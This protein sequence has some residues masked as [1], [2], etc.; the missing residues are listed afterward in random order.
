M[1]KPGSIRML[2]HPM[3]NRWRLIGIGL[4]LLAGSG[5]IWLAHS[6]VVS[7]GVNRIALETGFES[8]PLQPDAPAAEAALS[9]AAQA[10]G[11]EMQLRCLHSPIWPQQ[12]GETISF[13]VDLVN[14]SPLSTNDRIR[15]YIKQNTGQLIE[16]CDEGELSCTGSASFAVSSIA[17]QCQAIITGGGQRVDISSGVRSIQLG[18]YTQAR[19]VPV[20][21]TGNEQN[22]AIDVVFIPDRVSYSGAADPGFLD[23]V[24]TVISGTYY[25]Q[26]IYLEHQ[27]RLNF[28]IAQDTGLAQSFDPTGCDGRP[29]LHQL[30]ANWSSANGYAFADVGIILHDKSP[31]EN[32]GHPGTRVF[33]ANAATSQGTVRY[34]TG[35]VPFGLADEYTPDGGYFQVA[36]FPNVYLVQSDCDRDPLLNVPCQPL[37][38]TTSSFTW[39][40][41]DA[42]NVDQ[43]MMGRGEEAQAADNRRIDW[44][45]GE[46]E[47]GNCDR[48]AIPPELPPV[49]P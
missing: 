36:P 31:F 15:L 11:A 6:A 21:Y 16:R 49:V 42:V 37:P 30:P 29:C 44:L 39:Y 40:R 35:H 26:T 18:P 45:F 5:G 17:Y 25:G 9:P 23:A 3:L 10:T 33:S 19:A 38:N 24:H 7:A 41:V 13:R 46:C 12:A 47:M 28:W 4:V 14:Y 1:M 32:F 8:L 20:L 2:V 27:D 43:D 22:H 48:P 34:Q